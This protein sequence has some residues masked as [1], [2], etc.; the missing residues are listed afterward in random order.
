MTSSFISYSRRDILSAGGLTE[1]FKG[2][3]LGFWI[4]WESIPLTVDWWRE[5]ERGIEE[6]GIFLFL[7]SPDSAGSKVASGKLNVLLKSVSF[8]ERSGGLP[9]TLFARITV[10]ISRD[11]KLSPGSRDRIYAQPLQP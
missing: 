4:D 11:G 3:D 8:W 5:I 6:A 10:L 7:I 1:D 9:V 2:Q